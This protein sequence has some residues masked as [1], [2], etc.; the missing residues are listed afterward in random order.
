VV[1][2]VG[3][4]VAALVGGGLAVAAT[5]GVV[6]TVQDSPQTTSTEVVH[7]GER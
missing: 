6:S 2:I 1:T 4:V 5:V 7:Y 3:G